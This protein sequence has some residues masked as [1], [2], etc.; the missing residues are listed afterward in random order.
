[1]CYKL[2]PFYVREWPTSFVRLL[3]SSAIVYRHASCALSVICSLAHVDG[4]NLRFTAYI[5]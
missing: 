5:L 1:M 2:R 4:H 3:T